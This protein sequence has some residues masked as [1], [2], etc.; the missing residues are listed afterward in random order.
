MDAIKSRDACKNSEAGNSMEI[1]GFAIC[2]WHNLV[3][4]RLRN[5]PKNLQFMICRLK[6]QS[7]VPTFGEYSIDC[8]A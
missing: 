3:D 4:Q 6:E 5:E 2:G 1:C 7:C 8:Q